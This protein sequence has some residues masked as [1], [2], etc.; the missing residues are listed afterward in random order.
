MPAAAVIPTPKV[1]MV[2]V[3]VKR[4]VVVNQNK[5]SSLQLIWRDR[6]G[7]QYTRARDEMPGPL[8][9]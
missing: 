4:S 7:P 2:V 5:T 6:W 3:A 1:C 9:D 8:V